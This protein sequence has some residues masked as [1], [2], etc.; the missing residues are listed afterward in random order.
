MVYGLALEKQGE[1]LN[2][3]GIGVWKEGDL[4]SSIDFC[5][6]GP[7]QEFTICE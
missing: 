1:N 3:Y 7:P 4:K 6:F 2:E 5:Q